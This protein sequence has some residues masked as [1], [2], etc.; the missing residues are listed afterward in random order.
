LVCDPLPAAYLEFHFG[1]EKCKKNQVLTTRN[2][3]EM[4]IFNRQIAERN[5]DRN[6]SNTC[7]RHVI[8]VQQFQ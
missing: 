8:G 1:G 7:D 4:S 2:V 6:Y 3:T 5:G